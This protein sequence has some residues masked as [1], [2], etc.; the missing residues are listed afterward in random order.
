M[1]DKDISDVACEA[2]L[3]YAELHHLYGELELSDA[4]IENQERI[5]DTKDFKLQAERVLKHWRQI[6]GMEATREKM[7]NALKECKYERAKAILEKRWNRK[8]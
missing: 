4:D 7:L 8:R 5:S 1:S 6:K 2:E 3:T